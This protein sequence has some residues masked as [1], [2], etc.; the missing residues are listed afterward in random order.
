MLLHIQHGSSMLSIILDLVLQA[1]CLL[2]QEVSPEILLA[3]N[4]LSL[5]LR[6]DPFFLKTQ[7]KILQMLQTVLRQ[8]GV[9]QRTKHLNEL[10][11]LF[12]DDKVEK[13]EN[14]SESLMEQEVVLVDLQLQILLF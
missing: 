9:I 7:L 13:L 4:L 8:R 12:Q 10:R 2:L 6:L 3:S 1:L 5:Q 11:G 14:G